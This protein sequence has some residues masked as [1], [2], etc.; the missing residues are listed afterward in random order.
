MTKSLP[1]LAKLLVA[2]ICS[3]TAL[4]GQ[5]TAAGTTPQILS[6][7]SD[8]TVNPN[9]TLRIRETISVLVAAGG[10][11]AG[12]YRD[13]PASYRDRLGNVYVVHLQVDSL[14]RDGEPVDVSLAKQPEGLRVYLEGSGRT[15]PPGKHTYE[16]NYTLDRA[17]GLY[18][19]HDEL[20]WSVTGSGWTLPTAEITATVHLPPGIAREA[21]I[22]DAFTGA[23]FSA[24]SDYA[25][26]ADNQSNV[27]FRTIRPF[28]PRE[29]L[30]IVVRWPKRFIRPPTDDEN[31]HYF[32][33]DNLVLLTG[34]AGLA[35]VL[36]YYIAA[37]FLG[38]RR[39][40]PSLVS[41]RSSPP[42]GFSP[43]AVRYAWRGDFD[44]RAFAVDLLNLGVKKYI[45]LLEGGTGNYILGRLPGTPSHAQDSPR[46]PDESAEPTPEIASDEALVLKQVFATSRTIRLSPENQTL[47]GSALEALRRNLS[48]QFEKA[49]ITRNSRYL[50][51]GLLLSLLAVLRC[52]FSVP[53]APR[54]LTLIVTLALLIAGLA[55]AIATVVILMA[56]KDTLLNPLHR[57]AAA[58]QALRLTAFALPLYLAVIAGLKVLLGAT[59]ATT[60]L[61]LA[62]F[63]GLACA[64]HYVLKL[65]G[66]ARRAL[67]DEIEGLRMFLAEPDKGRVM[68]RLP[69]TPATFERFLP[70]ALALNVEKAWSEKF[71]AALTQTA[72][73]RKYSPAW[74]TGRG[75]SPAAALTFATSL[76]TSLTS[77]LVSAL[78]P[79]GA[80]AEEAPSS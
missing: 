70:Y 37:W 25:A 58:K 38:G 31:Y 7:H 27:T 43:A 14:E 6:Y 15:V 71:V 24:G 2:L 67:Q 1:L 74:Y 17:L 26:T 30:T 8:I 59:S 42:R 18:A 57:G 12:L 44:H 56:W 21:I 13:F 47:I 63:V 9:A 65:F 39:E 45:A 33:E 77:A 48:F 66:R 54:L 40:Q 19:D 50:V 68:S 55:A 20:Y 73:E 60:T 35:L 62:G 10:T 32:L 46:R 49:S 69:R 16:L 53:G 4:L 52:G 61:V 28:A 3:S 5:G 29:G 36:A 34:L 51:P 22:L 75:W 23:Q 72:P 64:F 41:P 76:G 80:K 79:S 78:T 11:S